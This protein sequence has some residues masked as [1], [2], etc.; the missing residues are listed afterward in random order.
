MPHDPLLILMS[1]PAMAEY[2][3]ESSL[4]PPFFTGSMFK[5]YL[6]GEYRT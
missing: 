5:L 4:T 6:A 2:G 3:D 1:Q